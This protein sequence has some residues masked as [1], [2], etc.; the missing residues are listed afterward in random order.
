MASPTEIRMSNE[1]KYQVKLTKQG[2]TSKF[3]NTV[4]PLDGKGYPFIAQ[5]YKDGRDYLYY[6]Y[7]GLIE[8]AEPREWR[9]L[10]ED[11]RIKISERFKP[12]NTEELEFL[13][14]LL[15]QDIPSNWRSVYSAKLEEEIE[16]ELKSR[17]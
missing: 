10:Q 13:S 17:R 6:I 3:W 15:I 9:E 16:V 8:V 2:K 4:E 5:P 11:I 14:D 12:F 7:K 1:K